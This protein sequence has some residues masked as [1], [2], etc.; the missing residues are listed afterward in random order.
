MK[1]EK[2]PDPFHR[3]SVMRTNKDRYDRINALEAEMRLA[4]PRYIPLF[5]L[6]FIIGSIPIGAGLMMKWDFLIAM[7]I[8]NN[9][10]E[11]YFI[12]SFTTSIM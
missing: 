6:S 5:G 2:K 1:G 7:Q 3:S 9:L 11:S 4:D 8:S 10:I 12:F